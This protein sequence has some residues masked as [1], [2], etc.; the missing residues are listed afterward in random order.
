M[1]FIDDIQTNPSPFLVE[2]IIKRGSDVIYTNIGHHLP[3]DG[4]HP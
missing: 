4:I 3:I 2:L 1:N